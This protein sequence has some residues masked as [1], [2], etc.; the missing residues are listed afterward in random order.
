MA[1]SQIDDNPRPA[2]RQRNASVAE[3]VSSDLSSFTRLPHPILLISMPALLVHPPSHRFHIQS[4]FSSLTA[5]RKCISMDS[6]NLDIECRAW[7]AFAELGMNVVAGGLSERE[8]CSWAKGVEPEVE[9]AIGKGLLITQKHPSLRPYRLHLSLLQSRFVQWQHNTKFARNLLSRLSSSFLPTDP[10]H[11]LYSSYLATINNLC[12]PTKTPSQSQSHSPSS[13]LSVQ[14]SN[15]DLHTALSTISDLQDLSNVKKHEDVTLLSHVLRLRV[16]VLAGMWE[17]VPDALK[18]CE[19]ALRL[20]Y[21]P[22]LGTPKPSNPNPQP[23][24]SSQHPSSSAPPIPTPP[25]PPQQFP[26]FKGVFEG[27]M[28]IHTLVM[29]VVFF[30]HIGNSPEASPRLTHLHI[31]LDSGILNK[32]VNG[33]V[34]IKFPS[35][36][37]L[38]IQITHP[39]I[40][41]FLTFLVSSVSKR[42]PVGRKPKKR[43]FAAEALRIWDAEVAKELPFA[44]W[45]SLGEIEE[46]EQR[47]AR[48]KA[49]LICELISVSIMRSEFQAAQ[50]HLAIL[51]AHTRTY[52]IFNIFAARITLHQAHLAHA[53]GQQ[54]RALEC[55][56]VAAFLAENSGDGEVEGAARAGEVGLRIGMK[57]VERGRGV[58]VGKEKVKSRAKGKGKEKEGDAQVGGEGEELNILGEVVVSACPG[59]GGTLQAI[60]HVLEACLSAEILKAKQHLKDA[61]SL[62]TRSQDNHLRALI[63]ALISSHYFHTAGEHALGMLETT[64]QL[65]AGLGAPS[66][67]HT[68]SNSKTRSKTAVPNTQAVGNVPLRLWVGERFVELYKRAGRDADAQKRELGNALLQKQ[69]EKVSR[70]R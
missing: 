31:L 5:I 43:I 19:E 46:V 36:P 51:I 4:L 17:S 70:L 65:A 24:Q 21:Q 56:R 35:S 33:I 40:L 14:Y 49:D 58:K 15:Q 44:P 45:M 27:A 54:E 6:L 32:C 3:D 55:Y 1:R 47:L 13:L 12:T 39:R 2:K 23:S 28:A 30:T 20:S 60:G 64:D 18:V 66:D 59:G 8:Y 62:A 38:S 29:A 48:I 26:V 10:P 34:D 50:Q 61:L 7:T 68:T 53:L 57:M 11:I 63:L 37:A 67:K 9:K 52:D 22:S 69:L 42:D 25:T 41:H 16:L